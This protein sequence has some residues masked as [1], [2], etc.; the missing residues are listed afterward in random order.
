MI[1][2]MIGVFLISPLGDETGIADTPLFDVVCCVISFLVLVLG[3]LLGGVFW[4]LEGEKGLWMSA[5]EALPFGVEGRDRWLLGV[6][7]VAMLTALFLWLLARMLSRSEVA[8]KRYVVVLQVTLGL[9][10]LL[11]IGSLID[12]LM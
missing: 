4:L 7:G 11:I 9:L 6:A 2:L 1:A 12:L 3:L 8:L 10:L 5:S